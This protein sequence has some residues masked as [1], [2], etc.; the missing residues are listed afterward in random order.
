MLLK[1]TRLIVES[2]KNIMMQCLTL[3]QTGKRSVKYFKNYGQE[4]GSSLKYSPVYAS[5]SE[6]SSVRLMQE[7][8]E[9]GTHSFLKVSLTSNYDE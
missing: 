3:G 5:Q 8:W 1:H 9:K 4:P 7:L 6:G 2:Q